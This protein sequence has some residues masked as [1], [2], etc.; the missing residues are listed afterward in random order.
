MS[1]IKAEMPRIFIVVY[2]V[3]LVAILLAMPLGHL[4][5]DIADAVEADVSAPKVEPKVEF[6]WHHTMSGQTVEKITT[7]TVVRIPFKF[8][9]KG[10]ITKVY[11]TIPPGYKAFG[12]RIE[13]D[14][15]EVR[16][17]G[18]GSVAVFNVHRGMPLGRHNLVIHIIDATN[19]KEI[20]KGIIPFILLPSGTECM[21]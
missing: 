21:C 20:G 6:E 2:L 11:F 5:G 7:E 16:E 3:V 13:S 4:R 18:V 10:E 8:K 12:I 1:E 17:G 15:S 9:I 14:V 19:G